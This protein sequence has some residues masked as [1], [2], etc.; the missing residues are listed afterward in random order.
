MGIWQG[1]PEI[2]VGLYIWKGIIPAGLGNI[3]GGAIFC[4]GY[5]WFMY[6]AGEGP[7]AIDGIMYEPIHDAK[8]GMGN[9]IHFGKN[10][11]SDD[12]EENAH[13]NGRGGDSFTRTVE[14]GS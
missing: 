1:A 4:G 6:L 5:Y 3:V 9:I 13:G 14:V 11:K 10:K 8:N 2:S 12:L 7:I